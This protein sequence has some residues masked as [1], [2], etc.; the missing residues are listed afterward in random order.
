MQQH[1]L[2]VIPVKEKYT[3]I[4]RPQ[5]PNFSVYML[6]KWFTGSGAP[7]FQDTQIFIN[8]FGSSG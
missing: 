7:G 1:E 3:V 2:P 8:L 6:D 4:A 5:F